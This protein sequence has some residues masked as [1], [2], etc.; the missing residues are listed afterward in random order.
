[1][2]KSRSTYKIKT[3]WW[4]IVSW[5]NYNTVDRNIKTLSEWTSTYVIQLVLGSQSSETS[6]A[7]SINKG[8]W[9]SASGIDIFIWSLLA[10][11]WDLLHFHMRGDHVEISN[12]CEI[13]ALLNKLCKGM[14]KKLG[15]ILKVE[16]LIDKLKII[17][18]TIKTCIFILIKENVVHKN[19][20]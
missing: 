11:K 2:R 5:Q 4:Y 15:S 18:M 20:S 1:M 10:W 6:A 13:S 16:A 19:V 8:N 17:M 9:Y 7:L 3:L 14:L 12:T